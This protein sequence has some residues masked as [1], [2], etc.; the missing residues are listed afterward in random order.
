MSKTR[1]QKKNAGTQTSDTNNMLEIA[2]LQEQVK[3]LTIENEH[4][5]KYII[6]EPRNSLK[7][8]TP[9][10]P[11]D[12][13]DQTPKHPRSLRKKLDTPTTNEK[14]KI[15]MRGCTCKGTC[16]SKIC[17]CVKKHILC[18]QLCKCNNDAC[19]NQVQKN[20]EQNKENLEMQE[21]ATVSKSIFSPDVI[22]D[23]INL[24]VEQLRTSSLY[25]GSPKQLTFASDKEEEKEK[26]EAK[27]VISKSSKNSKESKEHDKKDQKNI[28]ATR[29]KSKKI[30]PKSHSTKQV[31]N[32]ENTSSKKEERQNSK[33]TEKQVMER[34]NE[35][36]TKINKKI[37]EIDKRTNN[38]MKN[39]ANGMVSLRHA[40]KGS[41]QVSVNKPK[42]NNII[43]D[44]DSNDDN[45]ISEKE[46]P[47]GGINNSSK[48]FQQKGTLDVNPTPIRN[49]NINDD[50]NPMKP[51][52]ELSRTPIHGS[53]VSRDNSDISMSLCGT[54][55]DENRQL[56]EEF[57]QPQVD[58]EEYQ[59]QL[60]PCAKCK[61]K[62]HPLRIKKHEFCCKGRSH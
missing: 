34:Y 3:L 39:I 30:S 7:P 61:R 2:S 50:V 62:F 38:Y 29:S 15:P 8:T 59:S 45:S 13:V 22:K 14:N 6:E 23:D 28:L 60:V 48:S 37:K 44:S 54:V 10:T 31:E 46:V 27:I 56:P 11:T 33:K 41:K 40:Q 53:S 24:N 58:W 52:H 20:M 26:K 36:D 5:R 49:E 1:T 43:S 57:S 21:Y 47:Q 17:G 18:G 32:I 51:K 9:T 12:G 4:L 16:I 19:K 25:F 35:T 42:G 55:I